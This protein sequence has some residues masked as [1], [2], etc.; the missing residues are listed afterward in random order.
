MIITFTG[1]QNVPNR[2]AVFRGH[3]LFS[4]VGRDDPA[5]SEA[6]DF[7]LDS[8]KLVTTAWVLAEVGDALSAPENRSLVP[9][10]V[11]NAAKL[12]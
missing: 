10:L 2:E 8:V 9:E 7:N 11:G 4:R 3:I 1:R 6:A 5:H 12:A